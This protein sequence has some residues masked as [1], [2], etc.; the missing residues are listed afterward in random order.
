[1]GFIQ[2]VKSKID[3]WFGDDKESQILDKARGIAV[4]SGVNSDSDLMSG[5]GF[6]ALNQMLS[7]DYSLMARYVDY[8]EMDDYPE[9]STI[10]DIFAD[11]STI[12]DSIH[13]KTIWAQCQDQVIRDIIDDLLHRILRI[14]EDIWLA[15][16]TKCKYGNLFCENL[17]T[18]NG[19]VGLNWLPTPTMRRLVDEKGGLI[20]YVQDISGR[21]NIKM[22]SINDIDKANEEYKGQGII[23]FKP[24]EVTHWRL[25]SKGIRS[26]YGTG[27]LDS[28]RWIW[29]RLQLLED[30]AL[31][32]KLSRSPSRFIYYI[33]TGDL[34]PDEAMALVKK[35][36][37]MFRKKSL[38]NPTN[39][40]LELRNNPLGPMEDLFI[41]SRGGKE[42]TRVDVLSGIDWQNTED[43]QYFRNKMFSSTTVPKSYVDNAGG[44]TRQSLAQQ[45]VR[46]ARSC[47]RVQREFRNGMRRIV[48]LHL[49]L[50]NIDPDSI[51]WDLRMT[52]PSSIFEMQQIET[53]NAQADLAD[54]LVNYMPREFVLQRV[55]HFSEDEAAYLNSTKVQERDLDSK[56]EAR[57]QAE[58]QKLYPELNMAAMGIGPADGNY[59]G[60]PDGE[61]RESVGNVKAVKR[62]DD[63][64]R[65]VKETMRKG[66]VMIEKMNR[67]EPR[68]E[69]MDGVVRRIAVG[70]AKK[71][72]G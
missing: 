4:D 10:L 8:E 5:L 36:K 27:V 48:R 35:T 65:S 46:F 56:G 61:Q 22:S 30:T 25:R 64:A 37:N 72:F 66:D 6:K 49:A 24:W 63:L 52:V 9:L 55:L 33:D 16:R 20:G 39:G 11:D 60:R 29:K 53:L 59:D 7:I 54:K 50:L 58:I 38:I 26:I 44:E 47:M 14:E 15:M 67:M 19:L 12:T 1:M 45:D 13:G 43:L 62:L 31:M 34:P 51:K 41:A 23:F 42:S 21:F 68:L 32:Y 18:E 69:R 70:T 57:T 71:M 28:A 17:L 3:K 40:K 2:G